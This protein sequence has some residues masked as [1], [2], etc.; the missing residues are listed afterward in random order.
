MARIDDAAAVGGAD[1]SEN[2]ARKDRRGVAGE[3]GGIGGEIAQ[4]R[5][6]KGADGAPHRK[7]DEKA[8]P[9]LAKKGGKDYDANRSN[10]GSDHSEQRLCAA[11]PP[12]P[13]GRRARQSWPP[14]TV[15]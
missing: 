9:I 12:A 13:A 3:G 4:E 15:R 6:D 10:D 5:G 14:M 2:V 7:S 8:K 1:R 11:R